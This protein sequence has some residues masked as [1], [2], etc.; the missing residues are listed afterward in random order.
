MMHGNPTGEF[1]TMEWQDALVQALISEVDRVY[2]NVAQE[3]WNRHTDPGI[4]GMEFRPY[5]WGDKEEEAAL[6]NLKFEFSP[7]E[8]RWYKHIGRSMSYSTPFTMEE[9]VVWFNEALKVIR[10]HDRD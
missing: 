9:W 1:M 6:P 2:W 10:L 8:I 5:Y 4:K 7:Q 3:E